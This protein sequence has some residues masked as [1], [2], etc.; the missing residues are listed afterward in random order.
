MTNLADWQRV[1]DTVALLLP[2]AARAKV[3]YYNH[4]DP[5]LI[6]PREYAT[7]QP[8]TDSVRIY[9]HTMVPIEK[10]ADT[11]EHSFIY[12]VPDAYPR[13][14][15]EIIIKQA[16]IPYVSG[17][18]DFAHQA[19]GGPR[20]LSNAIV[21][22]LLGGGLGYGAGALVEQLFPK[23]YLERGKL[24]RTLGLTG[25]LGGVALGLNNAYANSKVLNTSLLRGLLTRNDS[26]LDDPD[27]PLPVK[28][29]FQSNSFGQPLY[30]P[31]ISVPQFNNAVWRDVNQG[32]AFNQPFRTPP[33]YA[34][35]ATGLMSG[36]SAG[37]N[38][39]IIRPTDVI[40]GIASAGVGLATATVAGKALSA[41]A[42]LTPAGQQ[43]LQDMGLWGGMMHAIVPS[44]FGM[45]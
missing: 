8:Y 5:D 42:G 38:S 20:P 31:T 34:A 24:R 35:A 15:Q 7:W 36:L 45:R 33:A 2:L 13:W 4:K 21:T 17:A 11:S 43:K 22:S 23:K 40:R 12:T 25:A 19:L 6:S 28:K 32:L 18:F 30:Q 39:P 44:I 3:A 9:R 37:R 16:A 1:P 29:A 14:D 10:K 26:V 27:V 41:L